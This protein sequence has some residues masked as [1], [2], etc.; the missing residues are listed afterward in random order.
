MKYVNDSP[1]L[2]HVNFLLSSVQSKSRESSMHGKIEV[3]GVRIS[4][5]GEGARAM[6]LLESSECLAAGA[7][8][9]CNTGRAG[10]YSPFVH[11]PSLP[12][13]SFAGECVGSIDRIRCAQTK[14]DVDDRRAAQALESLYAE[15]Y[16]SDKRYNQ[17][18]FGNMA[19]M[20][21]RRTM[22]DAV[23]LLNNSFPDY[24]F[25]MCKPEQFRF[26]PSLAALQS[27]VNSNLNEAVEN[28]ESELKVRTRSCRPAPRSRAR[29]SPC[30]LRRPTGPN[31]VGAERCDR[32]FLV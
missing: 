17:S 20:A 6:A 29:H 27:N 26:E 16:A 23:L 30:D 25:S 1:D 18:P 14:R 24:D 4:A 22:A 5:S 13:S 15:T 7:A 10:V 19:T 12:L 31:L 8:A 11:L 3:Y 2:A 21:S 9:R 32:Y 28:Y